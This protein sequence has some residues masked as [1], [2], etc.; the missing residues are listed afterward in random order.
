MRTFMRASLRARGLFFVALLVGAGALSG[1]G[2][3]PVPETVLF[4]LDVQPLLQARCVRCHGAGGTLNADS[5]LVGK[6]ALSSYVGKPPN[7]GFF[8]CAADRGVCADAAAKPPGCKRGF[9]WYATDPVGKGETIAWLPLMPPGPS[10]PLTSRESEILHTWLAKPD[11]QA[12][13]TPCP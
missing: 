11:F 1:C 9:R 7:Q 4:N 2:E 13:F 6:S 8:D 5:D 3:N 12:P 10:E